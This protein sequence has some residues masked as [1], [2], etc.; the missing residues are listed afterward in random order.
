[1]TTTMGEPRSVWRRD[2]ELFLVSAL[3]LFLELVLIRWMGTEIRVFAYLGNLILVVCF[4]GAGL[5]CYWAQKPVSLWQLGVNLFLIVG[6]IANPFHLRLFDLRRLTAL[7]N[8]FEDSLVWGRMDWSTLGVIVGL[9][10]MAVLLYL[11]VFVFV[12]LGQLL[13]G[14]L[15]R[16]PAV[17]R[18]Y[19]VNIAGSLAG[20][21]LFNALSWASLSPVVWFSVAAG[22]LA[23]TLVAARVRG[24]LAIGLAG[25]AALAVWLGRD[26]GV[27]TIWT[28][29]HRL[30]LQPFYAEAPTGTNRVQQ[31]HI[32]DVNGTFY[33]HMLN[34]SEEFV[35]AH[36][37]ILNPESVARG[38]YNLPF[39]FKPQIDRMLIVGA[40]S[41]NDAAAALRHG[42]VRWSAW[43]LIRGFTNWGANC[44]PNVRTTRPGSR[45][46][47]T[48]RGRISSGRRE[49]MTWCGLAG[50]MRTRWGRRSTTCGSITTCTPA[51]ASP[52]RAGC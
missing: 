10:L 7:L 12:P 38:H 15:Q 34:L 20:V 9:V 51:K 52:K 18:A 39:A 32:M 4:F 5:G 21:W 22:L 6:L 23:A 1:M 42:S 49:R 27:Q 31:G 17:I 30:T 46:W 25:L 43:R 44:I 48:M 45:S 47:W 16:H 8:V 41:G 50:W 26:T 11:V 2:A 29:Y 40:G 3:M 35:R 19:S 14:A 13:G 28:P 33:Q 36:P 37:D 24:G